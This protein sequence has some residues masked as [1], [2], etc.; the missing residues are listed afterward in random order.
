MPDREP[1]TTW[2]HPPDLPTINVDVI[3][4]LPSG[5][6]VVAR[7]CGLAGDDQPWW[8]SRYGVRVEVEAWV[9]WPE[10]AADAWSKRAALENKHE[11]EKT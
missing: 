1:L 10:E 2:R 9:P 5:N 3:A 8:E 7:Y 6:V 11:E 4:R